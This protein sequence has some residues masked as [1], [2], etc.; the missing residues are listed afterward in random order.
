MF[1]IGGPAFSGTTLLALLL[2]QGDLVCLDEPD[3]HKPEQ[4]HRGIPQLRTL[5]PERTFPDPPGRK[6]EPEETVDFTETC[7]RVV[8]PERLGVKTCD[9]TFLRFARVYKQRGYPVIAIV[10]DVRD[11]LVRELQEW[12]TEESFLRA[13]RSVWTEIA[14]FDLWLR[15]EDLV[16]DPDAALT[17]I[18][19]VL[20]C[21]LRAPAGW[22]PDAV[23]RTMLKLERHELLL[24]G[25]ISGE[26]VGLWR[27]SSRTFPPEAHEV[28]SL[29][30]YESLDR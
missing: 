22:P 16:A 27:S 20:S 26:R 12:M 8:E 21:P 4:D 18:S 25:R 14:S 23:Q 15:Y 7:A 29:M 17:R 10:R 19:D 2:N 24:S 13:A 1:L 9:S 30:G 6:L 5:F 3:F 28:A 11:V